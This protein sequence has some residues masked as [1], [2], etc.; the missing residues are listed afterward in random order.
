MYTLCYIK[1]KINTL[2]K[3]LISYLFNLIMTCSYDHHD[4]LKIMFLK[5][6][7][8]ISTKIKIFFYNLN[9]I[10]SNTVIKK[11]E[12]INPKTNVF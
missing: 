5:V 8:I 4:I 6:I 3:S 1:K 7:F 10:I 9:F 11:I 2:F 12:K